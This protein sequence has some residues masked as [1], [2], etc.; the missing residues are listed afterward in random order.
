LW[1]QPSSGFFP[2]PIS[3]SR[4]IDP[5]V[6]LPSILDESS[7]TFLLLSLVPDGLQQPDNFREFAPLLLDLTTM[8]PS[9]AS[10]SLPDIDN[11]VETL[12]DDEDYS[13]TS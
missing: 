12:D 9:G 7:F 5:S 11:C 1:W 4:I 3:T 6:T 2:R 13:S 8:I 10:D